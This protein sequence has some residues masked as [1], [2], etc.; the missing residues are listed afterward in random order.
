MPSVNE[1][2]QV[3]KNLKSQKTNLFP[4]NKTH[5][6]QFSKGKRKNEVLY[7]GPG[8]YGPLAHYADTES[9]SRHMTSM[10]VRN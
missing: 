3:F 7:Y 10:G 1:S 4:C 2:V 9:D 8:Y 5:K 6:Q